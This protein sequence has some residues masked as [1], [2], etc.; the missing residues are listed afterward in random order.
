MRA[1][2]RSLDI[3]AFVS[4]H[5]RD[6]IRRR[7]SELAGLALISLALLG[8]IALATWSIQDPSLSHATQKPIHNL[9]GFPGAIFSD[10]A[11]QLL[12]LA[13]ILLL[14][15]EV[16][17]GWRLVSHR[18]M[19]EKWRSLL[20]IV[21]TFLAAAFASALPHIVSWPLPTGLGGV[22]GD[23]VLRVPAWIFGS[24][25]GGFTRFILCILFGLAT[26][27]TLLLAARIPDRAEKSAAREVDSDEVERDE[28][29]GDHA[30]AWLGM[31]VHALLSWKARI[32][33]MIRGDVRARTPMPVAQGPRH[34][35]RFDGENSE[36]EDGEED[37]EKAPAPRRRAAA[38]ALSRRGTNGYTLPSLNLLAAQRASE[39]TTLS[40]DIIDGNATALES[41]LQDFG[42]RGEIINARPGP[43]VTLYELE[44]APGI[45]SSRV[46]GLADDIARS[47][48]AVSA[49][50]AVV[51][52][53]NAIGIELPNPVREKVYLRELL[54]GM[55]YNESAAKL[56]LC[57]GKTIGGESVIVDLSRMPHLLIA[58]TTGSG[59]SV[60]INT[61]ILSLVYRLRPDQCRL[62]MV[63][64]KMLELSVYDG[65]PHLLTPVVTDPKKA[66]VALKWAVRE[67][68]GRYK[69]MSKLGV[70][71]IDG[72]NARVAEAQAKGETLTRTVHTGYDKESGQA[73][74]EKEELELE[75]LP[76][77]VVIV[78]EMADLMM[79]AGKDIEGAI[80]RLAQ[81]AR[82]AGIHVILATQR[83]SVDVIT[84]TIKANFP[85]R[86]SFQVTSK[87][88]S[89]TI[90][91]EQGAEQLLGQGDMLYMAGGGRISRVHGPFVSDDEV[92]KVVRHLKS[93]G[94]PEYLEEV[95]AGGDEDED[96]NP[97]FDA[98]GMGL[99]EGGDI[100]QQAV[101]IIKRDRKA[102]TSYIQRRLQI[103][104]NRAATIMERMEEEGIV[105]Q[106]NHA[107]KR[108][109]LI[110]E[111]PADD[112]Y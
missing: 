52:G 77:L 90:L 76:F 99:A 49:R 66:V 4:E 5:F 39:R 80:Q 57:L 64:P 70:R 37:D 106:A 8:A 109:I 97:V 16:V 78:D 92:E 44:P 98:T 102:S 84:G 65:I 54:T 46:I 25:L 50:V 101:A 43:V 55:D 103:G 82:A 87:I 95:T 94:A 36:Y 10:L 107:G 85:T 72:Y 88:D 105:G 110:S 67:M 91:G 13:S 96:G 104:Y 41:V 26:V 15:P 19:G 53:R 112:R 17:L 86:I 42:V 62:I 22:A 23:A 63:D 74:Y 18:P 28:A 93:Q 56:P 81:M 71:N 79:V 7:L 48:S 6:I 69:K 12:G 3:I 24:P 27:V 83:P 1:A 89:R 108:E 30:S 14:V 47:M 2:D 51:S 111:N 73:V 40:R 35:P 33:R 75:P 60:A 45:K 58:G 34:E 38:R 31:I 20:W 11:M 59:K 61:M 21:A 32:G 68:E 100:Y 9:L 29:D